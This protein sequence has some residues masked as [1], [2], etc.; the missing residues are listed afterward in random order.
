MKVPKLVLKVK[1]LPVL[2]G[3]LDFD[4]KSRVMKN[5]EISISRDSKLKTLRDEMRLDLNRLATV[6]AE[7]RSKTERTRD[8]VSQAV[9]LLS[10]L[11][12]QSSQLSLNLKRNSIQAASH[13]TRMKEFVKYVK[14][15]DCIKAESLLAKFP[16]LVNQT[17]SV[18]AS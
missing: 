2:E 14:M 12:D 6:R 3:D 18:G 16:N 13:D 5:L 10:T 1:L 7:S 8:E 9:A 4:L 11:R 15:Q 17:D